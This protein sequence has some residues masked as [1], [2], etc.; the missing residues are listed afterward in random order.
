[1]F[2]N[3][4]GGELKNRGCAA[5]LHNFVTLCVF[6]SMADATLQRAQAGEKKLD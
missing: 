2:I 6:S 5:K 1:V 4:S 3:I